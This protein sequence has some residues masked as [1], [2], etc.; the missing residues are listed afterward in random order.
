LFN[1]LISKRRFRVEQCFGIMKRLFDLQ[2]AGYFNWAKTLWQM[3]MAAISQNLLKTTNMIT[4]I[5]QS[6]EI[7]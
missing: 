1:K 4:L 6:P 7:A 3:V 2:R 5:P